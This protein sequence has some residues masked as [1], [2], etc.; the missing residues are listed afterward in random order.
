MHMTTSTKTSTVQGQREKAW[1]KLTQEVHQWDLIVIGG[2]ITGAG[3]ARE[4]ARRGLSVALVEGHDFAWGTSSRSSK[5]IHGGLRYLMTGNLKLVHDSVRE[6]ERLLREAPG[7]VDPMGFLFANYRGQLPGRWSFSTLLS[8]YDMLACRWNH[9]HYSA[10]EFYLLAPRIE[11]NGLKGGEQCVDAVTDDGRLVLRVLHEAERDG[12]LVLNYASVKQLIMGSKQV[13]G[14]VVRDAVSG[15]IAEVHA[16]AVINATGAWA[17]QLREQVGGG[18]DIRPLRGSHLVFPFWRLPVAQAIG[19]LHPEDRR[20][21]FILPWEGVTLVG[22]T[23]LDYEGDLTSEPYSTPEEVDYLME[24]VRYQFPRLRME[25]RDILATYAGVRPVVGTGKLSPSKEKR[26]HSIWVEQGLISVSGG[27]L[28]TFRLIA[29]D[30]LKQ[31]RQFIPS[32]TV[33]DKADPVFGAFSWQDVPGTN[34]YQGFK[35]RLAGRYGL[36][37]AAV[38]TCGK[39]G[40]LEPLPGTNILWA[41]LRWAARTESVVHLDDLL[42]RRTQL[43][44]VLEQGGLACFD[45]IKAICCEELGW[46]DDQWQQEEQAYRDLWQRC[47]RAPRPQ[48]KLKAQRKPGGREKTGISDQ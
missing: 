30:V 38:V 44:I 39:A 17:D 9:R 45:R 1:L 28:T 19:L 10:P 43:G 48:A 23:D 8:V 24:I 25:L 41:E 13:C 11:Q 34:L 14:V 18:K 3:I 47:Y 4:A 29:L 42:L 37:A 36:E 27:K 6:R 46:D 33:R 35:R 26:N 21:V 31:V 20:A 22:S 5:M 7:L 15:A 2:G 12:A 16:H 32:L 40:E